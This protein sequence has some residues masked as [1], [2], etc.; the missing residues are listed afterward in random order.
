MYYGINFDGKIV[1]SDW[2]NNKLVS[3]LSI[4]REGKDCT[5]TAVNTDEYFRRR[6][7]MITLFNHVFSLLNPKYNIYLEVDK[8]NTGAIALY[9][10]LGF[11]IV[12]YF[13]TINRY[14]MKYLWNQ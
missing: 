11:E 14:K 2:D 5:I 9:E 10:K 6:G 1:Q 7:Y 4:T 3:Y 12:E 13:D 8:T